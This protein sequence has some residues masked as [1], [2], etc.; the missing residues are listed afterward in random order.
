[1]QALGIDIGG[2]GIKGAIV[3]CSTGELLTARHRIPTPKGAKPAD[4]AQEVKEMCEHFKWNGPVG[5]GFP[6]AIRQGIAMTA[7]N[8][9]NSWIGT[10]VAALF[11]EETKNPFYILNDADAAA[12]AEVNW[13]VGKGE[14]GV[15]FLVTIGTGLG[16]AIFTDGQLL[17]NTE[18][19]HLLLNG[20]DAEFYASDAARKREDMSWDEWGKRFN[21]YLNRVEALFW[22]DKFILGGGASKKLEKFIDYID[23]KAPIEAAKSLNQAGIIGAATYAVQCFE[24]EN[25]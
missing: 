6:A 14:Q 7:A 9:D 17:P 10:D 21:E 20:Y 12:I 25:K 18:L 16:T 11:E 4:V 13:G 22:P 23:V 19:G 1:M 5:C 3:D 15:V 2:S 24:R 8:I